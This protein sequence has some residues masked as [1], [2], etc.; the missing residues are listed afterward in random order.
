MPAINQWFRRR[1]GLAMGIAG[2]GMAL[3]GTA[4]AP[5]MGFL[6]LS[7]GWRPAAFI[8]G[9]VILAVVIPLSLLIRRDPE[10]MGLRPDG[11]PIPEGEINIAEG[12]SEKGQ[13]SQRDQHGAAILH[14][15]EPDFTASEAMRTP[16]FWILTLAVGLQ[17]TVHSGTAFLMVPLVV[18]FLMGSGYTESSAQPKRH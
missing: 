10:S 8:S 11:D 3:G 2:M 15:G 16:T 17:D 7:T 9:V 4:I 5:L 18:W 12:F 14:A 6:V 1:L 13:G